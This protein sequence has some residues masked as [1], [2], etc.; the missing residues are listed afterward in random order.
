MAISCTTSALWKQATALLLVAA[1]SLSSLPLA[2]VH[3]HED[4][5]VGHRHEHSHVVGDHATPRN[6]ELEDE[7][8]DG[9]LP[10][11]L[12]VHDLPAS[13]LIP[14]ASEVAPATPFLDTFVAARLHSRPPDRILAPLFR[15]P[16]A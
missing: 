4:A 15:P 5:Y 6:G 8:S 3:A 9:G 7:I 10:D 1:I 13:V 2:N 11:T 16:I 14:V 12:H